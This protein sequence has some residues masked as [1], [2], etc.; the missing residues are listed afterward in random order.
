MIPPHLRNNGEPWLAAQNL[1]FLKRGSPASDRKKKGLQPR[2]H[3]EIASM[4]SLVASSS[5]GTS[6]GDTA[7]KKAE[8]ESAHA[9]FMAAVAMTEFGQSPIGKRR[10]SEADMSPQEK[11]PKMEQEKTQ[12]DVA[13][14]RMLPEVGQ[15][16]D[17]NRPVPQGPKSEQL[18]RQSGKQSAP[19]IKMTDNEPM[20]DLGQS[21][22]LVHVEAKL[23]GACTR[24]G[25]TVFATP[26]RKATEE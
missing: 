24:E 5:E 12:E 10:P 21:P 2:D 16:P 11:R 9:L 18:S 4:P 7:I 8:E 1:T 17:E 3:G 6:P 22:K 26:P 19:Q 15:S 13:A 23:T 14:Q 25:E 20:T